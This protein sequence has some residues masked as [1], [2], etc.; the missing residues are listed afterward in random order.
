MGERNDGDWERD[1]GDGGEAGACGCPSL[2]RDG[3]RGCVGEG[4]GEGKVGRR[5]RT[6]SG[7]G[8]IGAV[9]RDSGRVV[10]AVE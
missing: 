5:I 10:G 9:D 4:A 1:D 6:A 2:G 3:T 7:G 8:V